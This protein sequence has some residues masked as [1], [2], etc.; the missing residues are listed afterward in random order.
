M[1]DLLAVI[2][3]ADLES[4]MQKGGKGKGG[5]IKQ[6]EQ[7]LRGDT[8]TYDAFFDEWIKSKTRLAPSTWN[9]YNYLFR[10]HISPHLGDKTL[11]SITTK[12]ISDLIEVKREELATSCIREMVCCILR[13]SLKYAEGLGY[14]SKN[15]ARFVDIPTVV[16][17]HGRA[18][19]NDE[20]QRLREEAG[21]H[22][23]GIAIDL[24][25][26]TGMR[27]GEA[28]ALTWDDVDFEKG[29]VSVTKSYVADINKYGVKKGCRFA[30]PKTK[31]SNRVI[32]IPPSLIK[33]L[34]EYKE[35]EERQGRG[36]YRFILSQDNKDLPYDTANF[37]R[38]FRKW[39]DAA[40]VGK[41][42]H[43]HSLRHTY[44]TLMHEAGVD[45]YT[46]I[47]QTG[48]ADTRMLENVYLHKRSMKM[49]ENAAQMYEEK[50][51]EVLM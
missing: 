28:L 40:D 23:L 39:R 45:N 48:H 18:L 3:M 6:Y 41:E 9:K 32:T 22:R 36:D 5:G 16:Q 13:Q 7:D 26:L 20:I 38:L 1:T 21:R 49:Q 37:S 35:R 19:T 2:R 44:C 14:I 50:I 46:L 8:L 43:I 11:T 4:K 12:D 31:K 34:K 27:R 25:L 17:D 10:L 29:T 51:Q 42:I 15:V 47:Q 33:A 24:L 30:P